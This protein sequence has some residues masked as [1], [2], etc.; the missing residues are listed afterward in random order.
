MK[1]DK[2]ESTKNGLALYFGGSNLDIAVDN[3]KGDVS[4]VDAASMTRLSLRAISSVPGKTR[5]SC[6]R[7]QLYNYLLNDYYINNFGKQI[8]LDHIAQKSSRFMTIIK[9]ETAKYIL[10]RSY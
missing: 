5:S 6:R 1:I 2:I 4:P 8:K 9:Y 3:T 10:A 7:Q